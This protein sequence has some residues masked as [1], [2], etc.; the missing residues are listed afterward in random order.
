[1]THA[2]NTLK[3]CLKKAENELQKSHKHRGLRKVQPDNNKAQ[4]YVKKAEHYLRATLYLYKGKYSDIC[5]ST[6]F[7]TMYHCLMA[8]ATKHGYESRNQ[9]CT[10][11]VIHYLIETKEILLETALVDK[12]ASLDVTDSHQTTSIDIRELYQYG[13]S[14]TLDNTIYQENLNLAREILDRTKEIIAE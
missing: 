1:M 6:L 13:T 5:A 4:E 3:W 10:F 9:T 8:I 14:T 7:Y 2:Q 11:A 12:V